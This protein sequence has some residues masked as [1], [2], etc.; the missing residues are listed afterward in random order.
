METVG[1]EVFGI[2]HVWLRFEFTKGRGQIHAHLLGITLE[3][4]LLHRFYEMWEKKILS[5]TST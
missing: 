1:K 2:K 3:L 4:H 5:T